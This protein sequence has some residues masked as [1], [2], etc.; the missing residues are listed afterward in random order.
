M[1]ATEVRLNTRVSRIVGSVKEG[2]SLYDRD[3]NK[4]G[5]FDAVLIATPIG[6][7]DISLDIRNEVRGDAELV[8][9]VGTFQCASAQAGRGVYACR[10]SSTLNSAR[11]STF[12]LKIS[13]PTPVPRH[14]VEKVVRVVHC[15][16]WDW[17]TRDQ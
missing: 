8:S 13:Q 11:A 14:Q 10:M 15:S 5:T 4:L 17:C 2:Y 7:S 16:Y 6:L 12:P 9:A 3:Q 1:S